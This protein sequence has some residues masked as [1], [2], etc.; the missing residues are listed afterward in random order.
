M[1][2]RIAGLME[3]HLGRAYS[4]AFRMAGNQADAEDLVQEAFLR[5][6]K[7]FK[8]YDAS[9][10]FEGWLHQIIRNIYLDSMRREASRRQTSLSQALSE[11]GRTLE[12]TLPETG[13]GPARRAESAETQAKVQAALGEL[14][15]TLRM[16][17]V[18]VDLEGMPRED[19]AAALGCSLS[20]LDV[21]LH[22]A[23]AALR[24]RLAS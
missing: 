15:A 17:V 10:P 1:D 8:S 18:L 24:V 6:M 23:R 7:Y 20:A 19:A 21:R 12:D 14:S 9:L 5:V 13:P 11:E 4:I 22:R 2:D 3:L 16:P